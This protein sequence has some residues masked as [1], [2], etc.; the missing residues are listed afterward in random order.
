MGGLDARRLVYK[1]R[2]FKILSITTV[3]TPHRGSPMAAWSESLSEWQSTS[4]SMFPLSAWFFRHSRQD[5]GCTHARTS[6]HVC[7]SLGGFEA[8][9]HGKIQP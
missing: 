8:E 6:A 3:A 9:E 5:S 2:N 1:N 7:A 4:S